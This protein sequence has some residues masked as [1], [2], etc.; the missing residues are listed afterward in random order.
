LAPILVWMIFI[1]NHKEQIIEHI[2]A[3]ETVFGG[4]NRL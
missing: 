3:K 2:T 1:A 4:E